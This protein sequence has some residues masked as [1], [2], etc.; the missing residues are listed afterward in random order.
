LSEIVFSSW[1]R[2]I[3]DNREGGSAD[4]ASLK[5]KIPTEYLYKKE[6]RAFMGWDGFVVLDPKVDVVAMAAEYMKRIQEKHCCGKCTPGKKGTR[7]LQDT[8][9]RIISGD[10]QE[11]DLGVI[12]NLAKLMQDCKCTLCMTAAIPVQ[13]SV[14][15]FRDTYLEYLAGKRQPEPA[16][17]YIDKVTAP[18]MDTCPAH[19][20]IPAYIEE[21]KNYRFDESLEKIRERMAIPAVCGRVCPHPCETACR[22]ALVD[23]SRDAQKGGRRYQPLQRLR[24]LCRGLPLRRHYHGP[25]R[26]RPHP[27]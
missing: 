10:G 14:T 2:K 9:A 21:I 24:A 13:D 19:I 8:L 25:A 4:L 22:R 15:H 16:G 26:G 12:E 5:L 23:D 27:L 11:S 3:V 17:A 1:G 6:V 18:C 7:V 20:D